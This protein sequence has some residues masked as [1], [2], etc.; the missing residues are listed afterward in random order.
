MA[1][2]AFFRVPSHRGSGPER[3]TRA[4]ASEHPRRQPTLHTTLALVR[5]VWWRWRSRAYLT[6]LNDRMLRDIGVTRAEA[7]HERDKPLWRTVR[8]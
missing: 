4:A 6:A 5:T 2:T 3:V 7:E 1:A 8:D